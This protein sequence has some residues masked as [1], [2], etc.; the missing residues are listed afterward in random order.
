MIAASLRRLQ[1][2]HPDKIADIYRDSDG[3]WLN[4]QY[5]W[6]SGGAHCVHEAT[7]REVI[8]AFRSVAACNCRECRTGGAEWEDLDIETGQVRVYRRAGGA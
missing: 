7:A 4:L 2:R 6:Q 1:E 3:L 5:G 8:S